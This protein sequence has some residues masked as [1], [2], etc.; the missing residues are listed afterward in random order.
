MSADPQLFRIDPD[1]RESEAISEVDFAQLGFQE[2]HDIQE[3]IAANPNILGEQLLIIGKEFSGFDRTNERLDLL[4]VDVD[5]RLVVIELKRDD[6]GADAHWQAIK[7]ASYLRR[8]SVENIVAMLAAHQDVSEADARSRLLQHL[9][10]DDLIALNNDQRIILASHKFAPEVTS[11][12]LWLNEKSPGEDLMTCIQLTPYYD[13]KN[14][15]LYVQANRIIPVP[16]AEEYMVGVGETLPEEGGRRQSNFAANLRKAYDKNRD[17]EVTR[18][19]KNVGELAISGL[20]HQ[21]KPDKTSRWAGGWAGGALDHRYYR[22]WYSRAPWSNWEMS[23][24][25]NLFRGDNS[26]SW[27]VDVEFAY[28]SESLA[29]RIGEL[30][31]HDEQQVEQDRILVTHESNALD[32]S[33]AETLAVTLR[34]FIETITPVVD[35]FENESNEEDA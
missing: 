35:D 12:A 32:P 20:P 26:V 30:Q 13:T 9:D 33:F 16:G 24:R 8:A 6:T 21:V 18:F 25:L 7:Y 17:D 10:V 19:L 11:A 31:I 27:N 28:F 2:R 5:G 34:R 1:S 15:S 23:H 3:W 22:L 4:A 14:Q 29:S